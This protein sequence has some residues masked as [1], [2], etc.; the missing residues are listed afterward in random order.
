[1][2]IIN[3]LW[4]NRMRVSCSGYFGEDYKEE[5]A[6]GCDNCL[7]PKDEMEA[8]G[9]ILAILPVRRTDEKF[10]IIIA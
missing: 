1:M 5:S 9:E 4:N 2:D 8:T 3:F 7:M 6:A 10:G